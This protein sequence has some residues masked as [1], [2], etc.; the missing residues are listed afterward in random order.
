[1]IPALR[2]HLQRWSTCG[3]IDALLTK[4]EEE[5]EPN[6]ALAALEDA[7]K[8]TGN[9]VSSAAEKSTRVFRNVD[10]DGDGIPDEPQAL[11]ASGQRRHAVE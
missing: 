9:W 8:T 2:A 4:T 10:L 5:H 3:G 7:A 1:M 11:T 6:R